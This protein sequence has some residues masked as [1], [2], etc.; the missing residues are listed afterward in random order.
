MIKL[1][2]L[3]DNVIRIAAGESFSFL[4]HQGVGCFTRCCRQLELA[5][6][7]YDVLRLREAT[8]LHSAELHNRYIIVE[9]EPAEFFPRYYLTMVDDGQASCVFVSEAG[10][11]IYDH[12][13]G[14]CRTYPMGRAVIRERQQVHEF[15]V[16]LHESHC[17]GFQEQKDQTIASYLTSQ[18]LERYNYFNDLL[19]EIQQHHAIRDGMKL[20]PSHLE[21]YHLALFDIDTFR[22]K[23]GPTVTLETQET[24]IEDLDDEELLLFSFQWLKQEFFGE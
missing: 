7:P 14:A 2:D 21:K 13:P 15:Y 18:E 10:C 4:C 8:N 11:A 3:P 17:L 16:L 20:T 19:S 22:K 24:A 5:L 12:R 1:P 9:K 6:T 23:I